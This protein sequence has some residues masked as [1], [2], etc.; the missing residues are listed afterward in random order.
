MS[1]IITDCQNFCPY[2]N[3]YIVFKYDH[4]NYDLNIND[5]RN[6]YKSMKEKFC[7]H[8]ILLIPNNINI[9]SYNKQEI[10]NQL[11]ELLQEIKEF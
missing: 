8:N 4:S 2:Q 3:D 10:I 7:N 11:E 9:E 6:F 1:D 5:L